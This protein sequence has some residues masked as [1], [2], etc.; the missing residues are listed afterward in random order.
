MKTA[1]LREL[2]AEELGRKEKELRKELALA[3]VAKAN[4]QLKNLVKIRQLRREIACVL[5][6]IT[7][8]FPMHAR[9][10]HEGEENTKV[11]NN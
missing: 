9:S 11:R 2:S 4:Q 10:A 5:T 6:L 7:E 1:K 3:R 8:K